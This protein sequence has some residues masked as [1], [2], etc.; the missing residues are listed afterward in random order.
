MAEAIKLK[1][2]YPVF[3]SDPSAEDMNTQLVNTC[4]CCSAPKH[5][6]QAARE[7]DS[8]LAWMLNKWL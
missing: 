6:V 3:G 2:S 4:V 1:L 7:L 5:H 8:W